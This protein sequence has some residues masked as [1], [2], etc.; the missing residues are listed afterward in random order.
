MPPLAPISGNA[1]RRRPLP[2]DDDDD[3]P[4]SAQP[5]KRL[6]VAAAADD[7]D[8]DDT[9]EEE[10]MRK[11]LAEVDRLVAL[12]G[13]KSP[14]WAAFRTRHSIEGV[15]AGTQRPYDGISGVRAGTLRPDIKTSRARAEALRLQPPSL[16][17]APSPSPRSTWEMTPTEIDAALAGVTLCPVAGPLT[18]SSTDKSVVEMCS[19]ITP[20]VAQATLEQNLRGVANPKGRAVAVAPAHTNSRGCW[21][22]QRTPKSGKSGHV[23]C[24][25]VVPPSGTRVPDG[26]ARVARRSAQ[27]VHRLAVRAWKGIGEVCLLL[28]AAVGG[29]APAVP[30]KREVSHLCGEDNCFNPEHLG[31]ES[32]SHNE[33]RKRC[34]EKGVCGCGLVPGCIL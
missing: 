15:R 30:G 2:D 28:D 20:A 4:T 16:P 6:C 34:E 17:P 1:L 3:A 12:R 23:E 24:R 33:R 29:P 7:D 31:V 32:H 22:S 25:P 14:A 8:D 10:E 13:D 5:C 19:V 27:L 11:A 21:L 9:G 26:A 18:T